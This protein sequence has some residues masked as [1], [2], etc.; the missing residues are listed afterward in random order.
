MVVPSR[1]LV[2]YG[3]EKIFKVEGSDELSKAYQ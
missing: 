3:T 1:N 2:L